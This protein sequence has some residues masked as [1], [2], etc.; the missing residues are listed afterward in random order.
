MTNFSNADLSRAKMEK[1]PVFDNPNPFSHFESSYF[2]GISSSIIDNARLQYMDLSGISFEKEELINVD[3]KGSNLTNA[4]FIKTN[5]SGANLSSADL[6]G[7][8]FKNSRFDDKTNFDEAELKKTYL[9][10]I[11]CEIKLKIYHNLL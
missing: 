1:R 3:F 6:S 5:L 4:N 8:D 11:Y 10:G 7:A 2:Y 9:N